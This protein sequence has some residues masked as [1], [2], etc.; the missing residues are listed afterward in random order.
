MEENIFDILQNISNINDLLDN[1][2]NKFQIIERYYRSPYSVQEKQRDS[3]EGFI[4]FK[5][6]I[7]NELDY[8]I[9]RNRSFILM[10]LDLCER[11]AVY[12]CI[13]HLI[14][15]I[16]ANDIC[17][18]SRIEAGLK[19]T[20]PEP[21]TNTELV[22]KLP[23]ICKLLETAYNQEEDN[24][25]AIQIT[26]LNYFDHV[27]YN[28]NSTYSS[29]LLVTYSDIKNSLSFINGLDFINKLNPANG[30]AAHNKIQSFIATLQEGNET[31]S[32]PYGDNLII[33]ENTEYSNALLSLPTDFK[34]I[35]KYSIKHTEG[36]L[37]GRGVAMLNTEEEMFEYIKRFGRMHYAKL[38]SAFASPFPQTFTKKVNIIDWGCGQALATM[39]FIEKYGNDCIDKI[40]LIEPSEIVL[41]RAALHC[42]KFA[43]KAKIQT[44]NKK[45]NEL[46]S[47]DLYIN[48]TYSTINLFSNIL[49]IDDYHPHILQALVYSICSHGD[50]FVCVSPHIDDVKTERIDSFCKF[51]SKSPSFTLYHDKINNKLGTFWMC[52][53]SYKRG[54]VGHGSYMNCNQYNVDGCINK[55]TRVLKVFSV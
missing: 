16:H 25:Y 38:E 35:R 52:N 20:Y 18:N 2:A 28:T 11:H 30:E 41:K 9:I 33:E 7:L 36:N 5:H 13:P 49:D 26:L 15:I 27:F 40:V 24:E 19:F 14:K 10:L 3:F 4:L 45:L 1:L 17:I 6:S 46:V 53:N 55:W 44:V 22:E 43:P 12:S 37:R 42:K 34:S 51:F 31:K 48:N 23:E 47:D 8:T 29:Q 39:V 50:Y 21:K 32:E 54:F